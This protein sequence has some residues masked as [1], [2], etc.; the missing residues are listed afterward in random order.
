MQKYKIKLDV[1][2][3]KLTVTSQKD[4]LE[5]LSETIHLTKYFIAFALFLNE[6]RNANYI[7]VIEAM[8]NARLKFVLLR[9]HK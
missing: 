3:E 6:I 1:Q 8:F 2:S 7:F 9:S 4:K 5:N